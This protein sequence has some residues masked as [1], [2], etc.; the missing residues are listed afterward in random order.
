M[1]VDHWL[2]FS[3]KFCLR[4]PEIRDVCDIGKYLFWN[5]SIAK[6]VTVVMFILNNT[7]IQVTMPRYSFVQETSSNKIRGCIA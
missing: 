5:S 7:F 1:F 2:T 3:R 6:G 4:H